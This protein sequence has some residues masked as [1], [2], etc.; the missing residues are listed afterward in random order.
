MVSADKARGAQPRIKKQLIIQGGKI[1]LWNQS[2]LQVTL[3]GLASLG[4][5]LR[6]QNPHRAE[7]SSWYLALCTTRAI[8]LPTYQYLYF[9]VPY[10]LL[11]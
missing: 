1:L 5:N 8:N 2:S 7:K 10:K 11:S 9:T 3:S 6:S 4:H